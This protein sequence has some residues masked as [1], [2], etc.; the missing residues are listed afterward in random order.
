MERLVGGVHERR[1]LADHQPEG[2]LPAVARGPDRQGRRP[3]ADVGHRGLPAAQPAAAGA[4]DHRPSARHRLPEAVH[5]RRTG[6]RGLRRS[7]DAGAQA[8]AAAARAAGRRR[9]RSAAARIRRG[10]RRWSGG[11]TTRTTTTSC[12]TSCTGAKARRAWKA[13]RRGVADTI[14]V[15]DTTTV[16]NG[17][18]FVK[19]VASDA[20]SNPAGT[21]LTGELDSAAFEIDNT[22]PAIAVGSVR[23]ERGR[24]I[25]TFDVKDDHSP[26]QRVEFSRGRPAVARRVPGRRHRRFAAG[27]LRAGGRRRAGRARADAAGERRDEQRRD[28]PRRCARRG[29]RPYRQR[30][31]RRTPQRNCLRLQRSA[32][33]SLLRRWRGVRGRGRRDAAWPAAAADRSAGLVGAHGRCATS[34]TMFAADSSV[35]AAVRAGR[36]RPRRAV[37]RSPRPGRTAVSWPAGAQHREVRQP[38]LLGHDRVEREHRVLL[39]RLVG[40]LEALRPSGAADRSRPASRSVP[41]SHPSGVASTFRIAASE[42]GGESV[43]NRIMPSMMT[44]QTA[45]ATVA[46]RPA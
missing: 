23:V 42:S 38:P 31:S 14:L 26:I 29:D 10:C 18:Y 46:P 3:G 36:A 40:A 9:P 37:L 5:D 21:A 4:L 45:A 27:A 43:A 24:T 44:T 30:R 28:G 13:L 39:R 11:P 41:A 8:R 6:S 34:Q 1:G 7:D 16:P 19:V 32:R 35:G 17:T 20:P 22:P 15:W 33:R 25:V 12:T 2:A